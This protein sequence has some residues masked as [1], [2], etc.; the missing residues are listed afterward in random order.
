MHFFHGICPFTLFAGSLASD[1]YKHS[2]T[3][4]SNCGLCHLDSTHEIVA[5]IGFVI[6]ELPFKG[7]ASE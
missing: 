6:E 5:I 7:P 1:A 3:L 2:C 4:E